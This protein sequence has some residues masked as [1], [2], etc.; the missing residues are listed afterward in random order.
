MSLMPYESDAEPE[1]FISGTVIHVIFRNEDN[2]YSVLLIRIKNA[3]PALDEKKATV[4]GYFPAIDTDERYYF[5]GVYKE[6]PRF[7]KQ[8]HVHSYKKEIPT[9]KEALITYL[10][11]ERFPG[12]GDKTAALLVEKFGT[13]VIEKVLDNPDVLDD[14]ASLN[15]QRK[16]KIYQAMLENQ[17][18]EKAMTTLARYGFGMELAVKIYNTYREQTFEV[19]QETPY[20]LVFDIEGIGFYK[21]DRLGRSLGIEKNHPERIKAG[22]LYILYEKTMQDGHVFI[23]WSVLIE[24]A[25]ALLDDAAYQ[26]D[27]SCLENPLQELV[28]EDKLVYEEERVYMA[29][30]YFAEKGFIT[31]VTKMLERTEET[32]PESEFLKALGEAEEKFGIEYAD[33]QKQAIQKA[34]NSPLMI[35]TGGPGT[36]KTTVIRAI[37]DVFS[38]LHGFSLDPS[39][40][41]K[42]KPFPV[43][44]AAPTGR[45]AKRM[46]ESTGLRASTIH[47]LLGYN[48]E[49]GEDTF[50]KDEDTPLQGKLLIIDEVSM[51]DMWL[52]NQ[53]FRAIPDDMQVI[54][55]GDE[56]QLPS[57]GPG[58]VLKDLIDTIMLPMTAL[59]VVYRQAEGSSIVELAHSIKKGELPDN[60]QA[61]FSDRRFFPCNK[62]QTKDVIEKVC[63]GA[64]KKGYSPLDIQVLAPMY[65]GPAGVDR[66]NKTL[67]TLYNPYEEK[68]RTVTYGD[69]TYSKGD[70]VLQ[71]IN[72]PEEGVFN[73]DRGVIEAIFQAKETKDKQMQIVISFDGV[74]VTY[75]KQDLSQITLAYCTTI[76]KA[77]GSEFPIV[78]V[79]ML[80]SYRRMLRRNLLY[81]AITRAKDYLIMCGETEAF[82]YAIHHKNHDERYTRLKQKLLQQDNV[83]SHD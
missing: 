79:P 75:T 17:G 22:I 30:L 14:V 13:N 49:D 32:F 3:K 1:S 39:D 82:D 55:V 61:P 34:V 5:E 35:L 72:N 52:A 18:M 57:V 12:I 81:T 50:E 48:G 24:Q 31:K 53:L 67:Q 11:S 27:E 25:K 19:I 76:H 6:H 71:L 74:E 23:P 45:A 10:S 33:H 38:T 43:L 73:G 20:R 64:L 4:V 7:G 26:L 65:K 51:V 8:Y 37:V 28:E 29:S 69:T 66:L 46:K 63:G 68:K 56:D 58:Q 44:L 62:E 80:M 70:V 21:A 60:L 77:Q 78:V 42:D 59:S 47:K 54:L 16:Q 83:S 9:E 15:E 41:N 2:G 40:Y 36:G